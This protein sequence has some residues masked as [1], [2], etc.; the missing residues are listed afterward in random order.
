MQANY[1][2][3]RQLEAFVAVISVG[4]MTGAA[5][6]LGRSQS[7]VTRLIQELET[8]LGFALLHR[9]G[10]RISPTSQGVAFYEQ[11]EMFLG[12][13]RTI[14]EKARQIA[15]G[16]PG[17]IEVASIPALA[18]S[19]VPMALGAMPP[20]A[21]PDHVHLQSTASENV[22]QAVAARTAD[23]GL[24]SLPIGNPG[25]ETHW[26]GESPCVAVL[27]ED[28]PLAGRDCITPADLQGARLIAS[29]NP[30]RLRLSINEALAEVGVTPGA[31]I[32]SNATYVSLALARQGIGIAV[33]E[34]LTSQG[35]PI[36]GVKV[37]PISVHIP[38]RWGVITALGRPLSPGVERLI[39]ELDRATARI[40]GFRRLDAPPR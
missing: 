17:P 1:F 9:N 34:G 2:D 18:A 5:K 4:S 14:G 7:V 35:L 38:F 31:V 21:L 12:G 26:I 11:A 13:L 28:H 8:E 10:P 33:V 25:I 3:T 40:P 39:A 24:A 36:S 29:A 16:R 23:L 19:L 15:S 27:A 37:L 6:A 30:Y 22:V 20:E 32:D